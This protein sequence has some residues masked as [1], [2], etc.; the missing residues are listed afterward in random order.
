ML[1]IL[2][3]INYEA[4]TMLLKRH[5]YFIYESISLLRHAVHIRFGKSDLHDYLI[6]NVLTLRLQEYGTTIDRDHES[7]KTIFRLSFAK[8]LEIAAF[9]SGRAGIQKLHASGSM[10]SS[11]SCR[12]SAIRMFGGQ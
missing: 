10:T 11:G 6:P 5:G 2:G 3:Y 9:S 12:R 8:G 4:T 1:P 7:M